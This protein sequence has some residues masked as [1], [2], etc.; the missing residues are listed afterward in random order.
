MRLEIVPALISLATTVLAHGRIVNIT[1]SSGTVYT[2][3]DPEMALKSTPIPQLAAWTASNLGNIFVTPAQF[4]TSNITCHYNAVPGPLHINTTA[5][6]TLKLQWNEW[7]VSHKGPVMTYL[8]ACNASCANAD[9]TALQWVKIDQQGWLN[10]S[11]WEQLGG[12][13]AS[14]VLIANG[15]SWTVKIP[16][17]LAPGY[18]VLRHEI[19]ALHVANETNG[20]QAYPQC[21]NIKVGGGA[22]AN[23]Q[24]K[25][26]QGG[27]LGDK[28][29]SMTDKGIL[30][31]IH[32]KI[33]GY[34]I[35]GPKTWQYATQSKQP[36]EKRQR[37]GHW[38]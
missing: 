11:G 10:S 36:N 17:V 26:L 38:S 18:Y 19:I 5:G 8:A 30:V 29:Y 25:K 15:A 22:V 24:A 21:V 13:W 20:A 2:G 33:G 16:Q 9:K 6:D 7:P 37:P 23:Q 28:L 12:T 31:D 1:T 35:P 3:W 32:H 27:V 34:E 14:D 4:N